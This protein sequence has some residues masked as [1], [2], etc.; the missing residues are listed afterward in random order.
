MSFPIVHSIVGCSMGYVA[1]RQNNSWQ[2]TSLFALLATAADFDFI[3]GVLVGKPE[4][5]HH[6]FTHSFMAA[7]FCGFMVALIVSILKKQ[8][9]LKNSIVFSAVY[10]SHILVDAF[11][12]YPMPV[13]WPFQSANLS[14][15]LQTFYSLPFCCDGIKDFAC[16][17]VWNVA[18]IQ[19]FWREMMCLGFVLLFCSG[20]FMFRCLSPF[21]KKPLL[22]KSS[23]IP[24]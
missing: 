13:F 20:R 11:S 2:K 5:F 24:I 15:Q 10:A 4:L 22:P 18:C 14:Q 19:R 7:L 17:L 3:P 16:G 21:L 6:F 9:L 8:N 12:P 23:V 1:Q